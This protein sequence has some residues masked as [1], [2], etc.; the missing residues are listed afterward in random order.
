MITVVVITKNEEQMI[1]TCLESIKWA[2]EIIVYDN[3]SK[4][5]TLEIAK[6]YTEKIYHFEGQD[7]ATLRNQAFDKAKG[8]WVLYVDADERVLAPLKAEILA[9]TNSSTKSAFAISRKNVIFGHFV[10]YGPYKY[11]WM[12]RLFKREKFKGWVGKVHEHGTFEGELG[13]TKNSMLHLT[14]RN[15]DHF[16]LKALDWTYYDAK[17]RFDK[18]HPKMTKWRFLRILLSETYQQCIKRRGLFGG[19]VG[20]IDSTLQVFFFFMSYVRL[21][22]M[23]QPKKLDEVYKSIDDKLQENGFQYEK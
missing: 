6:K 18:G 11:D 16:I 3:G 12:I 1:K 7:F 9:I 21:W 13:Y 5:Q 22:E 20:F 14:H 23:Q 17:L 19:T 8:D 2:N 10:D 4:D 15:L